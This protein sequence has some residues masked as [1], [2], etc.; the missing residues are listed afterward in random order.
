MP[1]HRRKKSLN[2]SPFNFEWQAKLFNEL[3]AKHLPEAPLEE[4]PLQVEDLHAAFLE[5]APLSKRVVYVA[6][7]AAPAV[8]PPHR[9]PRADRADRAERTE[10]RNLFMQVNFLEMEG[11]NELLITFDDVARLMQLSKEQLIRLIHSVGPLPTLRVRLQRKDI[12]SV[13]GPTVER[14]EDVYTIE[15]LMLIAMSPHAPKGQ[16]YEYF[17]D[18]AARTITQGFCSREEFKFNLATRHKLLAILNLPAFAN[19]TNGENQLLRCADLFMDLA[20]QLSAAI[21]PDSARLDTEELLSF[22]EQFVVGCQGHRVERDSREKITVLARAEALAE[23][24]GGLNL[25]SSDLTAKLTPVSLANS[26][27]DEALGDARP[28]AKLKRGVRPRA[29]DAEKMFSNLT[30]AHT[31][32]RM[33][34]ESRLD[35]VVQ[36]ASAR[37]KELN[38]SAL[39]NVSEEHLQSRLKEKS[40]RI[41]M[42][43][44]RRQVAP[45]PTPLHEIAQSLAPVLCARCGCDYVEDARCST[46]GFSV[47][48]EPPPAPPPP[49]PRPRGRP[50]KTPDA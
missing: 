20:A 12:T 47:L 26:A 33:L 7:P 44:G 23:S 41:P 4:K 14:V 1:N 37:L 27:R 48:C 49:P 15:A 38:S 9:S 50:R 34:A 31:Q 2:S 39:E 21:N 16:L 22:L 35:V 36:L 25:T 3:R 5:D 40:A 13:D 28:Q 42:K 24:L 19:L 17:R 6:A 32:R 8:L 43:R 18:R 46:S 11:V 45:E 30:L 29:L 10:R